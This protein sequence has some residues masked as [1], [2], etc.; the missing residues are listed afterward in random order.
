MHLTCWCAG[1][2][3]LLRHLQKK[4]HASELLAPVYKRFFHNQ[5]FGSMAGCFHEKCGESHEKHYDHFKYLSFLDESL[6]LFQLSL[7][8]V[9]NRSGSITLRHASANSRKMGSC[10]ALLTSSSAFS[11]VSRWRNSVCRCGFSNKPFISSDSSGK[12][13]WNNGY[14]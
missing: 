4:D 8:T 6:V 12:K 11:D 5:Y 10:I 2:T 13:H 3:T 7:G 9:E 14:T 1:H